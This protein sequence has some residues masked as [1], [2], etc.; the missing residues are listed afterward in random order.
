MRK[1]K[2]TFLSLIIISGFISCKKSENSPEQ[3]KEVDIFV[4]GGISNTPNLV[5]TACYWK[6]GQL[7]KVDP[8]TGTSKANAITVVGNDVY[9]AGN[10]SVNSSSTVATWWKNGK[11][12]Y[13]AEAFDLYGIALKGSDVFV[14]GSTFKNGIYTATIWKN[15]VPTYLTTGRSS[16]TGIAINGD[17]VYVTGFITEEI[18]GSTACY[19]KNGIQ[20][21]LETKKPAP[22]SQ[23]YAIQIVDNDVYIAGMV[24]V[25]AVYWKNNE[26]VE[27]QKM[28][29][30]SLQYF[31]FSIYVKN[32][33]VYLA[34]A[35]QET[36]YNEGRNPVYWK[37]G[38]IY[39]LE[40]K[41]ADMMFV[42]S[43]AK[44]IAV[45]GNNVYIGGNHSEEPTYFWKNGFLQT[46]DTGGKAY[47]VECNAIILS[48]K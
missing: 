5:L 32:E 39:N 28:S 6:N 7:V 14:V 36:L 25:T 41:P 20:T 33:D 8:T 45:D 37:N 21:L 16:A 10:T 26:K 34:G 19:W 11:P 2:V 48:P 12:N 38:T 43:Q 22:Q 42:S 23:T 18:I 24:G 13:I 40:S 17:D 31:A 35:T 3:K 15:G 4:A 27:L 9:M 44:A 1:Y 29:D 30:P 47:N 46:L